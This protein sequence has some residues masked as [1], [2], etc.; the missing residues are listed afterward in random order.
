MPVP[1]E[2]PIQGARFLPQATSPRKTAPSLT[3]ARV[4]RLGWSAPRSA[5]RRR[6]RPTLAPMRSQPTRGAAAS[7][8]V[9]GRERS[10]RDRRA[11]MSGS[12]LV[13]GRTVPRPQHLAPLPGPS[14]GDDRGRVAGGRDGG[15]EGAD[16][17][18]GRRAGQVG[19]QAR[20]LSPIPGMAFYA[21]RPGGW[22]DWWTL[23]HPPDTA[24]HLA[25]V[26][27]GATLAPRT[28]VVR[29]VG[30]LLAFFL[31]VGVS[32]HL[33]DELHGRAFRNPDQRSHAVGDRGGQP[34]RR[35]GARLGRSREGRT[36][37]DPLHRDR[38]P[39]RAR[40]R[41]RALRRALPL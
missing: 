5:P 29:F 19:K 26:V 3:A 15:G 22:R 28:D 24:W 2:H 10:S 21:A 9:D 18:P 31:A 16:D 30:V 35:S 14:R 13:P 12:R 38:T 4:L 17:E 27:F 39:A 34:G 8:S 7:G 36:G 33:F 40:L 25:D 6:R 1:L 23:L 37:I 11:R 32:A 41:P 20:W